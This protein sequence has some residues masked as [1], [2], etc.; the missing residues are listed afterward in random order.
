[1]KN[2]ACPILSIPAGQRM[3]QNIGMRDLTA[4]LHGNRKSE[5]PSSAT[6]SQVLSME[7]K[8]RY[9]ISLK[10][11]CLIQLNLVSQKHIAV[12]WYIKLHTPA[13]FLA[14]KAKITEQH[15][16]HLTNRVMSS[17]TLFALPFGVL[18][19]LR[20]RGLLLLF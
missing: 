17:L 9:L 16:L 7:R 3:H 5:K 10:E 2:L 19:A 18:Q 20:K 11:N 8:S 14:C 1:M 13:V 4:V 6:A 12:L 15:L